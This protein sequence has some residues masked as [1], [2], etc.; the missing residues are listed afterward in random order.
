MVLKLGLCGHCWYSFLVL[1]L[2]VLL[3]GARDSHALSPDGE[4]LLR[5]KANLLNAE[6]VLPSWN[7][8]DD[9]P[10]NWVGVRCDVNNSR[11]TFLNI[12]YKHLSGSISPELGKLTMLRRLGLHENQLVGPIPASVRNLTRLRALY[13][14]GNELSGSIPNELG[15]LAALQVLDVSRNLLIGSIPESLGNLT[16]LRFLNLSSNLL[17]GEIP[18]NGTL[19]NFGSPSF[20]ENSD[21]CGSQINKTC[22]NSSPLAA[23]PQP[24]PGKEDGSKKKSTKYVNALLIAVTGVSLLF[25][26]FSFLGYFLVKRHNHNLAFA[27]MED[28]K[29][30][31]A[32]EAKLVMF[33]GDLPYPS[34]DVVKKIEL[35]N[36]TDVIGS[37]G[38]GTVYRLVM[39]DGSWF[40][41]KKIGKN[42]LGSEHLFE[43]E[44]EI[45]GS[46]KHR[47]LVNLRGFCNS[48]SSKLLIY[49]Y[50]PYGSLDTY[51][52]ER[53]PDETPLTWSARL[54]I[55]IGAARALAYLHHDCCPRII[56]RDIKSSN[57]LL[58]DNMEPHVSD[59]GLAKLLDGDESHV[60]TIV[61]GTFGYLAPEYLNSG[62]ATEKGDVYS[63][64]V[65]L[66]ELLSGRRPTDL[67]FIEKGVNLVGWVGSC[68]KENRV[69][70]VYDSK[71]TGAHRE[72][73]ENVLQVAIMCIAADPEN[74]PTMEQVVQ[75][76]ETDTFFSP[77]PSELEYDSPDDADDKG[78]PTDEPKDGHRSRSRSRDRRDSPHRSRSRSRDRNHR[79][80]SHDRKDIRG[81]DGED[82]D[83]KHS[84]AEEG[85]D[86]TH[87][88]KREGLD[89]QQGVDITKTDKDMEEEG[90]I[91]E[92]EK[93]EL[94]GQK[95]G[96][97]TSAPEAV[98]SKKVEPLSLEEI[99]KKQKE[100]SRQQA[101]PVFLK[102]AQRAELALKRRQEQVTEQRK[103]KQG[104][105][106]RK[107]H[108]DRDRSRQRD[109]E[110]EYERE[111]DRERRERERER[112][113]EAKNR[114]KERL[115]KQ[116]MR[117]RE[118]E[119]EA[120]KEQ[121]L[122][123]TKKLKKRVVKPSKK[124]RFSFDWENTED[125][126][127]DMNPISQNPHEAQL[128]FGRGFRAGMDRR[129]QK[130]LAAKNEKDLRADIRAKDGLEEK[131]E[132][133]EAQKQKEEAA[134]VYDT[135]DMRVDRHWSQKKIDEMT[136][137]DWRIF[138]EDFNI[139][140]KGFKIPRP[141]RSW[142]EGT[143]RP[144]L[145]KAVAKAGYKKPSPIQMAAIPIGLQQRDVIGI[146]ETGSGK[147]AAFFLPMLTYISKLPPMTEETEAEGPYAVVMAPTRE[148]A[149]QIEEETVKFAHYLDGIRV[150]SIVGADR[151]IDMRFEVQL[152]GVLDAMPS[153]NVNP[154]NE[155]AEE[156]DEKRIYRT[157]Y[158]FSATMPPAVERLARKLGYRVTSLHGGKTQEQREISL[159]GFRNKRYKCLVATDVA[160]RGIDIPDVAHVINYDMPKM[161]EQYTHRNNRIGRAVPD[162][163]PRRND[164]MYAH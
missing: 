103:R 112:E 55:A 127:R 114:E 34:K 150:V 95:Q 158:M 71:C 14:R 133:A 146:A 40:A 49:D 149:Q 19:S 72:S 45:L 82:G 125:T 50:L 47:N 156:L 94:D 130:K 163:P 67:A 104:E 134:S 89:A 137:R 62:R 117:E 53:E 90:E 135:F 93:S 75:M 44:L 77:C 131:P 17:S 76:L 1:L 9:T 153:S 151:M 119:L 126:S 63:Y 11:V 52:H 159:E 100:E 141:M 23:S 143:L 61:A 140:Y 113:E 129:E 68:I 41:V 6:N 87:E 91:H 16:R 8:T 54:R 78:G 15:H 160:G 43:R 65:V 5:F 69:K 122:G 37:G 118:K 22:E 48:P 162:R 58:D 35:L 115:E 25:G 101:K 57:I 123:A 42:G 74:R 102:K 157:T 24:A 46:F 4:V 80:H 152:V 59:F 105:S 120:I 12:P 56:H 73:M 147:T 36:D 98:D 60:S 39:D 139:S 86:D 124:F 164:T 99:L 27:G 28:V 85:I 51:L 26:I 38:F 128:L 84:K 29:S 142:E 161:I 83:F 121:Y 107:D 92:E 116:M 20:S 79:S 110:R 33:H 3:L 81:K 154:D 10:C 109:R 30:S 155:D 88:R 96:E 148:L 21:L 132:E 108:D 111:R 7:K 144:E 31:I 106:S 136:E 18:T 145:L 32:S 70:D 13:L 138:R 97:G 64:G 66:L 2:K